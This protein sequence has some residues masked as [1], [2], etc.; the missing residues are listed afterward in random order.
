MIILYE[1]YAAYALLLLYTHI[2]TSTRICTSSLVYWCGL[3]TPH[4]HTY[5]HDRVMDMATRPALS[6]SDLTIPTT[7]YNVIL[8]LKNGIECAHTSNET[9][10]TRHQTPDTR[11]Q[12]PDTRHQT[13]DTTRH[14][15]P[16]GRPAHPFRLSGM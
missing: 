7:P 8:F 5:P 11:H 3:V 10:D 9:P 14:T 15:R 12:T 2:R 13:P 4:T 16:A 6:Q 1:S